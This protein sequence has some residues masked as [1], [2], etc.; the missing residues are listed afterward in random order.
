MSGRP[1]GPTSKN[2]DIKLK[3]GHWT[4]GTPT[5]E[6][7]TTSPKRCV[8][9]G[10]AGSSVTGSAVGTLRGNH[11]D[12]YV[13]KYLLPGLTKLGDRLIFNIYPPVHQSK[14]SPSLSKAPVEQPSSS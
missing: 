5:H 13:P 4:G 1:K 6:P 2:T 12:F 14:A 10:Q 8:P 7:V 9:S 11:L 3:E